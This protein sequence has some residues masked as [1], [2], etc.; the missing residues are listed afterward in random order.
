MVALRRDG[1]RRFITPPR[2]C[3]LALAAAMLLAGCDLLLTI[4]PQ[5][6][7]N[8]SFAYADPRL[9]RS[10]R[11]KGLNEVFNIAVAPDGRVFAI[12]RDG[13][14]EY[15]ADLVL[16]RTYYPDAAE[17]IQRNKEGG[18]LEE[19]QVT[20]GPGAMPVLFGTRSG[21]ALFLFS[22]AGTIYQRK[23]FDM[24]YYAAIESSVD[25]NPV[26]FAYQEGPVLIFDPLIRGLGVDFHAPALY[27]IREQG[28]VDLGNGFNNY[29]VT[30]DL[31]T[32]WFSFPDSFWFEADLTIPRVK[33]AYAVHRLY[34]R[35]GIIA[36]VMGY[37]SYIGEVESSTFIYDRASGGAP[38]ARFDLRGAITAASDTALYAITSDHDESGGWIHKLR[39]KP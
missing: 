1:R 27:G 19:W 2:A 25:F 24:S 22:S 18:S 38:I 15:S 5:S 16:Q 33:D 9:E 4:L 13:V 37:N 7:A 35:A 34:P 39:F 31:L 3:A 6:G 10:V 8:A 32:P 17:G 14:A 11:I 30:F 28:R 21:V 29:S 23:L 26:P 20:S 12:A 36:L